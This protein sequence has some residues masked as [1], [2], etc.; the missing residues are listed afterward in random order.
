M[1]K[2]IQVTLIPYHAFEQ[3]IEVRRRIYIDNFPNKKVKKQIK[4]LLNEIGNDIGFRANNIKC[5][6][7]TNGLRNIDYFIIKCNICVT[8][9]AII[10]LGTGITPIV[11]TRKADYLQKFPFVRVVNNF[12]LIFNQTNP[13]VVI[14]WGKASITETSVELTLRILTDIEKKDDWVTMPKEKGA[15][16]KYDNT[17]FPIKNSY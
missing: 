13:Y 3:F 5:Q 14:K 4:T 12:N 10:L 11:F 8:N 16:N 15:V 9:E 17:L 7:F 2:K 6:N 1:C